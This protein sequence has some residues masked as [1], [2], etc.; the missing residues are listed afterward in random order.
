[1]V[2]TADVHFDDGN[3]SSALVWIA[4]DGVENDALPTDFADEQD[5]CLYKCPKKDSGARI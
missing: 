2:V 3:E 5:D 1:M 4:A